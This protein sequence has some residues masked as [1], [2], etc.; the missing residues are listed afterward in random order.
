MIVFLMFLWIVGL[1]E[2]LGEIP[3]LLQDD[4]KACGHRHLLE[5]VIKAFPAC[6]VTALCHHPLLRVM[7]WLLVESHVGNRC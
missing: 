7:S 3:M 1:I 6:L 4:G 5:G 2:G